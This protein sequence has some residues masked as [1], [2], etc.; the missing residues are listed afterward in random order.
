MVT[1]LNGIHMVL[2]LAV[3]R[4]KARLSLF[5]SLLI[6]LPVFGQTENID[7]DVSP[8]E[9]SIGAVSSDSLNPLIS[10]STDALGYVAD[11]KGKIVAVNESTWW[12]VDYQATYEDYRLE[13]D[14]LAFDDSQDFYAYNVRILSRTYISDSL[15]A[16]V[17]GGHEQ[18]QQKYGEGIT[19]FRDDVLSVDTLTRNFV[20]ST[21]VYGRDPKSTALSVTLRWQD[22]SYDDENDYARLFEFSQLGIQVEGRYALSGATR[23]LARFSARQD[24]YVD[25]ERV[26]NDVYRA[27]VGV[28]WAISGKSSISFLVGGF[29][30]E[31]ADE[32]DRSGFSW[33][34]R[35]QYTPTEMSVFTLSSKRISA[36]S[37]VEFSSD[38]IDVIHALDWQYVVNDIWDFGL[39]LNVLDKELESLGV[40]RTIEQFDFE[41]D[42]GFRLSSFQK[43]VAG[44]L[45][46]DVSSSDNTIDY[47]QNEVNIRWSYV[48]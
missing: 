41:F 42:V 16:D 38:S 34:A 6:A 45:R 37:E 25:I 22:D 1:K 39:R 26:D 14:V 9:I 31:S 2:T 3:S 4:I 43:L 7:K 10:E 19:R 8:L 36:V 28:D 40:T 17:Q 5:L 20:E 29:Q 27:L 46:R 15:T 11:A 18:K 44:V 13:D 30:R 23:F 48:F 33:D 47:T 21:L 12:Q 32:N 35:Y 24:D